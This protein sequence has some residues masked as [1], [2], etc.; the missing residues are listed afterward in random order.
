M[1]AR[2]LW[3]ALLLAVPVAAG[4]LHLA[5]RRRHRAM[6][7]FPGLGRTPGRGL[8]NALFLT[9]LTCLCLAAAG[10]RGAG[11]PGVPAP[12]GRLSLV[13]ALDVSRSMLA[14]DLSPD[15]LA[16]AKALVLDVLSRLPEAEVGLVGFAGRAWLACPLTRDRAGLALFL[17]S[18]SPE[19]A[20]LGGTSIPAALEAARLALAATE[21]GA[22]LLV[23]DG[24]DTL[25][26]RDG[27]ERRPGGPPV[28]TVAV[29]GPVPVPVPLGKNGMLR[30]AS[31][32]PVL[33]GVGAASLAA[34]ARETGGQAFR[35]APQAPD[36]AAGVAAALAALAPPANDTAAGASSPDRTPFWGLVG[37]LLLLGDLSL[38][39]RTVVAAL[40]LCLGLAVPGLA[41][42]RSA[43]DEAQ[44]FVAKG[45]D[46]FAAGDDT[47]ALEAFLR[48]RVLAPDSPE[49]LFDVGAASYRLGRFERAGELFARAA[50]AA[51]TPV[52]RAKALY[53]QGNAAYRQGDAQAAMRL[54]EAALAVAPDDA[55]AR[56]NLD[57]LRSRL[58]APQPEPDAADTGNKPGR[59]PPP[60]TGNEGQADRPGQAP[61]PV[62]HDD[63]TGGEDDQATEA[64]QAPGRPDTTAPGRQAVP[65]AA[66]KGR[67]AGEKQAASAGGADDPILS[68]VPDRVGLPETPGYGR[69]TVEKDW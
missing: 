36:P 61:A 38:G 12:A 21:A 39:P 23:C 41:L 11:E 66:A 40:C 56:A 24:E 32:A 4:F 43:G 51:A 20:P 10:P 54:Y 57:W 52:L 30:D 13:I 48:A 31:G 58:R 37:L 69:P 55:D 16:A 42:A 28:V 68:R 46:A 1:F 2:P 8:K 64:D 65:L 60:E 22:V 5:A 7:A 44:A 3:L 53:N 67:K 26:P 59:T 25:A 35:L 15:R 14:R 6:A 45:L 18:L 29:G 27:G 47:A 63:G 19:A 17:D 34:V 33:V 50:A 49:L 62:G 9:G